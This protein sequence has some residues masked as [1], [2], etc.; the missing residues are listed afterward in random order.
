MSVS[1]DGYIEGPNREIDRQL[2]RP[3]STAAARWWWQP[4]EE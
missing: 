1:L 2:V 3:D 4:S